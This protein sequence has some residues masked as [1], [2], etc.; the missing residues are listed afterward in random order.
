MIRY[1]AK[2]LLEMSLSHMTLQKATETSAYVMTWAT[3]GKFIVTI[4]LALVVCP[5]DGVSGL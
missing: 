5:L 4:C 1:S 3:M 2:G